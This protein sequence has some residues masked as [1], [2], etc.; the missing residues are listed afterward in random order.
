MFLIVE[1]FLHNNNKSQAGFTSKVKNSAR[2]KG[3][4]VD[5]EMFYFNLYLM[6]NKKDVYCTCQFKF[7]HHHD[8][9]QEQAV[10][11]CNPIICQ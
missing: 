6:H 10:L 2:V 5:C 9:F 11:K 4:Q 3:Q 1:K 8:L 7:S